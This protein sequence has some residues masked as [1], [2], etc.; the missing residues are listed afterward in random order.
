MTYKVDVALL[1]KQVAIEVDG[2]SH[3]ATVRKK[4]DRK[5]DRAL[6]AVGWSVLRLSNQQAMSDEAVTII[7]SFMRSQSEKGKAILRKAY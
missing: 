3:A 7:E 2:H 5:K 4:Q 1:E 6:R